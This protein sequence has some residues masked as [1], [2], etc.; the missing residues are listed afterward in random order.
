MKNKNIIIFGVL[1]I[2]IVISTVATIII[3]NNKNG[4][5]SKI[6]NT[7]NNNTENNETF[8][9][10]DN[11]K[12]N[13]EISNIV[14]N[15]KDNNEN[16]ENNEIINTINNN[17][18][19]PVNYMDKY[20][21][22]NVQ[23]KKYDKLNNYMSKDFNDNDISFSYYGYPNDESDFY[24]GKIELL[25]N[26]YNILGITIGDNY[27]EAIEKIE[28][29]GFKR[30]DKPVNDDVYEAKLNYKDITIDIKT[31]YAINIGRSKDIS[32]TDIGSIKIGIKSDY[33]GNRIY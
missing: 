25:T 10:V 17:S 5:N 32:K 18:N 29:Y 23:L 9:T 14:D 11:N 16:N 15:N 28:S 22:S 26:K 31:K 2:I 24:L 7:I 12:D 13:N 1:V 4:E 19:L 30:T 33:L 3:A 8:N 6:N 21:N 20:D 27:K